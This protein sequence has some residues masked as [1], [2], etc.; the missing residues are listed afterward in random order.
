MSY[1]ISLRTL[2]ALTRLLSVML[3]SL[4][5][6]VALSEETAPA[7]ESEDPAAPDSEDADATADE[8]QLPEL[9]YE[10]GVILLPNKVATL[11]LT[12]R[13]R[14]LNPRETEKM[15]V[16]WGNPPGHKTL[17]A[18]V[19]AELSPFEEGGWAVIVTYLDDGHVDD[20]DAKKIDYKDVLE[21]MQDGTREDNEERQKAGYESI[22]L[23]GWAEQPHYDESSRKLFWAREIKFGE[24]AENTLN[25]D[26]RVL[27]REG[28]LSMNAVANM[29]QLDHVR[30][31]MQ[32]LLQVAAF[33]EGYRYEEYDSSTDRAA[34]YGIGALVAGG[35]AAKAG[36]FAKLGVMLL[37]FK[38]FF[39]LAIA[40]IGG[41][42]AK[43]FKRKAPAEG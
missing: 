31:D 6:S 12:D 1:V 24:S 29:P 35:L 34:A 36:L 37:A 33:N 38:K 23:V 26:V 9:N 22:E 27:G 14:Y 8:P 20:A 2:P 19:P 13:Y 21:D 11:T 10:T 3:L 18:V 42:L 39:I 30:S 43:I 25:Y 32:D 28:V 16:A 4:A 7:A 40:A 17:G 5:T 15:L 41:F